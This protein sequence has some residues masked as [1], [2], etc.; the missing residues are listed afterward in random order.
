[1]GSTRWI[2]GLSALGLFAWMGLTLRGLDPQPGVWPQ[3]PT[4]FYADGVF[5]ALAETP[6]YA[7]L[8][9]MDLGFLTLFFCWAIACGMQR[10]AFGFTV[11]LASLTA[12]MDASE[13][14]MILRRLGWSAEQLTTAPSPVLWVTALKFCLYIATLTWLLHLWRQDRQLRDMP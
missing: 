2:L 7:Q 10:P 11:S 1:M 12:M 9:L 8:I 4:L 14:L 5:A 3:A 13:D 6:G